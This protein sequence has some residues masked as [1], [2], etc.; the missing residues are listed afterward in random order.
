MTEIKTHH[1]PQ[2]VGE[3][4]ELLAD[5]MLTSPDFRDRTGLLPGRGIDT[6]FAELE[7]GLQNVRK[8]IGEETHARLLDLSRRMRA[9]FEADPE[10]KT[11]DGIKGSRCIVE[12]ED[13]LRK[14]G[15]RPTPPPSA[16]PQ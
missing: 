8:R 9:H 14:L 4:L 2:T 7:G 6:V 13:I 12:M 3:I 16:T 1:V 11:E 5:M 10:D 15:R